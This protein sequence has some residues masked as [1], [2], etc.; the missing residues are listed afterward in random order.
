M[1]CWRT[2][3]SAACFWVVDLLFGGSHPGATTV[4]SSGAEGFGIGSPCHENRRRA[5][6]LAKSANVARLRARLT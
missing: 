5:Y 2:P 3:M 1:L 4:M 6:A